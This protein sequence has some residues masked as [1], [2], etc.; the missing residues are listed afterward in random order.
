MAMPWKPMA[1]PAG[2][3]GQKLAAKAAMATG[4]VIEPSV[5]S[6]V[7]AWALGLQWLVV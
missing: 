4:L 7:N 6:C 1:M 2:S 5:A 3:M